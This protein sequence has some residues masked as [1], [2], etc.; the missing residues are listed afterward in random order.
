MTR[1]LAAAGAVMLFV[2]S[3]ATQ[4]LGDAFIYGHTKEV[5]DADIRAAIAARTTFGRDAH[6]YEIEVLSRDRIRLYLLPRK[7]GN[8]CVEIA[9]V[10]GKWRDDGP[11]WGEKL[12]GS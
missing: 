4:K 10:R 1:W 6:V 11:W 7:S 12:G 3:C 8:M 5:T 9:R 2:T